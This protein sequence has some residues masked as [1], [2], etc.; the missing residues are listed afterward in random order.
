MSHGPCDQM[1]PY[2]TSYLRVRCQSIGPFGHASLKQFSC[3][4]TQTFVA[5]WMKVWV[6]PA[7]EKVGDDNVFLKIF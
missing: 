3:D 2:M 5:K 6:N 1:W 4:E 7:S